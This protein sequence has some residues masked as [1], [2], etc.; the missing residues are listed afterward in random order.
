ML[1]PKYAQSQMTCPELMVSSMGESGSLVGAEEGEGPLAAL[2]RAQLQGRGGPGCG[3][4]R[5]GCVWGKDVASRERGRSG[6]QGAGERQQ[7]GWNRSS[8]RREAR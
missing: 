7:P 5:I 3:S 6:G 8:V 1:L 2:G 4:C